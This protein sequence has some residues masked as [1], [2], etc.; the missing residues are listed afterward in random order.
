MKNLVALALHKVISFFPVR[1]HLWHISLCYL[2][3]GCY[4]PWQMWAIGWYCFHFRLQPRLQLFL[5]TGQRKKASLFL[6]IKKPTNQTK[7]LLADFIVMSSCV[8]IDL[9]FDWDR[10]GFVSQ[11]LYLLRI[12]EIRQIYNPLKF[13]SLE[14]SHAI[15]CLN[16]FLQIT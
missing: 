10:V 6:N 5:R 9:K 14:L 1:M 8:R 16:S 13:K 7:K 3:W 11:L 4:F 15:S 2:F 12:I